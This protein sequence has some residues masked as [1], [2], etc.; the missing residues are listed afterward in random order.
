ML[1]R[2]NPAPHCLQLALQPL[3][4]LRQ[5]LDSHLLAPYF[6]VQSLSNH[7]V[8]GHVAGLQPMHCQRDRHHLPMHA[9][10]RRM[11]SGSRAG[12]L[13]RHLGFLQ[14]ELPAQQSHRPHH[15]GHSPSHGVE[16]ADFHRTEGRVIECFCDWWRVSKILPLALS[17][18][19]LNLRKWYHRVMCTYE[20]LL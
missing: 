14:M 16:L 12:S 3:N 15:A 13:Y 10:P 17:R 2:T 18:Q 11:E 9:R 8:H 20:R 1:N 19:V 7:R 5:A 4:R 6:P